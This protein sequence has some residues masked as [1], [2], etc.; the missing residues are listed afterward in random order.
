MMRTRSA[1]VRRIGE[2]AIPALGRRTSRMRRSDRH[3]VMN[4]G[5]RWWRSHSDNH[6]RSG[7][8]CGARCWRLLDDFPSADM[9]LRNAAGALEFE[10]QSSSGERGLR[11]G[12]T[13]RCRVRNWSSY[14][15]RCRCWRW[16]W[17][18]WCRR[19]A[20]ADVMRDVPV[21]A[22]CGRC[23][24]LPCY[25]YGEEHQAQNECHRAQRRSRNR[26]RF[27]SILSSPSDDA[28]DECGQSQEPREKRYGRDKR[29]TEPHHS[30][31]HRD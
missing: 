10:R 22:G 28:E 6:D 27:R 14:G 21:A 7:L 2:R 31:D 1:S 12:G 5:W 26:G 15:C 17:G 16:S 8:H 3:D 11:S 25:V 18:L 30:Q 23:G 19:V 13:H 4:H 24:G 20:A 9:R 29:D